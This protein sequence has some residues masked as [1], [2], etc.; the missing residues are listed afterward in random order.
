MAFTLVHVV[1]DGRAGSPHRIDEP[2]GLCRRDDLVVGALQH[3]HRHRDVVRAVH[4]RTVAVPIRVFR[5][6]ADQPVEVACFEAVRGRGEVEE[7]GH[8]GEAH[9]GAHDGGSVRGDEQRG[10]PAGA[11]T[12]DRDARAVGPAFA[13]GGLDAGHRVGD[14]AVAPRSVE[15]A[16][17]GAPVARRAAGVGGE[18]GPPPRDEVADPRLPVDRG[19]VGRPAVDVDEQRRER[20]GGVVAGR[21]PQETVHG[22]RVGPR[23]RDRPWFGEGDRVEL[24]RRAPRP[25]LPVAAGRLEHGELRRGATARPHTQ[26]PARA[27]VEARVP[28]AREVPDGTAIQRHDDQ[29]PE[30]RFVAVHRDRRAVGRPR[31][32]SLPG[33]PR[34]LGVLARLLDQRSRRRTVGRREPHVHPPALVG[35]VR[36][37]VADRREARLA[38][39]N[40]VAPGDPA[41]LGVTAPHH[42]ARRVPRHVRQIPLVPGQRA[43]V[44]RPR[45]IPREVGVRD[46]FGP[47][48]P[49]EP[50][51]CDVARVVTLEHERDALTV[52]G[53]G[54]CRAAPVAREHAHRPTGRR[55]REE[56][57]VGRRV[58]QGVL[59]R[60]A[61][62]T[63]PV[64]ADGGHRELGRDHRRDPRRAVGGCHHEVD[65][66][67]EGVEP[68]QARAVRRPA[69]LAERA[70]PARPPRRRSGASPRG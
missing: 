40:R 2:L 69:R 7:I 13:P 34:W 66:A 60:P 6:R 15:G 42:D 45:G 38:D 70:R 44:G 52:R 27:P 18:H 1:L 4:R 8:A 59:G 48:G 24:P 68:R 21:E 39:G 47:R 28:P 49:V 36:E 19:L 32:R 5:Q 57:P 51:H 11:A 14:V 62:P 37:R 64:R 67:A 63:A 9:G 58:H 25:H 65:P 12:H 35:H 33:T 10:E 43:A 54:R 55:D 56:S 46:P 16:L 29:P 30:T 26:D 23:P 3:E 61:V 50:D 17:V 20:A 22:R 31:E 41:R 53:H